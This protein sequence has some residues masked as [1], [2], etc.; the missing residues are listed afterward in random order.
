MITAIFALTKNGIQLALNIS[1]KSDADFF[2]N[3]KNFKKNV[4][5]AFKKYDSLVFIMATGI[6]VRTIAPLLKNKAEDPAVVILDE[7][8]KYVI[9]LLSGHLGGANNLAKEIA[10]MVG[11]EPVITTATDVN[12]LPCIEDIAEK[13]NLAVEDFKKIKVVNSAIVNGRLVAFVDE[14][15]KRR[16]AIKGFI[17][18]RSQ[19]FKFYKSA[20]QAL[21]NKIDALVL[22]TNKWQ[23]VPSP[24]PLHRGEGRQ[25][26]FPLPYGERDRVRGWMIL[27]PKNLVVGIGCDRGVSAKEVE[28]AYVEVLKKWDVSPL[29][30]RNLASI[31]V[32]KNETGLL[33]FA[34]K[35]NLPVYFYSKNELAN[36]PLPSGF[37]KFVMGKVGVGGVC[38]PAALK[39]AG[40]KRIWIKKQ[41]LGRVTIAVAKAPFTL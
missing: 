26:K 2:I 30:V 13:F 38:E 41:K 1:R 39:S 8:G 31:D 33:R 15:V 11:A 25:N 29:S 19:G 9:S 40:T 21:K 28:S 32:K 14:D 20:A 36:M 16:E 12:N 4:R 22:I 6:V 10:K 34:K 17:G 5:Y 37:S 3:P 27:R 24:T 18:S 23:D 35:Y 7:K